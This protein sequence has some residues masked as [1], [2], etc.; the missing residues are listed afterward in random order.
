MFILMGMA[1][2]LKNTIGELQTS[3]P[4]PINSI[5][6]I[7][8]AAIVQTMTKTAGSIYFALLA[9][10]KVKAPAIINSSETLETEC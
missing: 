2:K 6:R 7:V 3:H 9:A 5:M 10:L 4:P 1:G 8:M